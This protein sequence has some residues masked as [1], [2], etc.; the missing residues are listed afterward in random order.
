MQPRIERLPEK[1][2]IGKQTT[3]SLSD[4]KTGDLWRSFMPRR[5]EIMNAI[6]SNLYS[7]QLYDDLY[8]TD[9]NP[10]ATFEKWAAIAVNDFQNIPD[11]MQSFLLE[12]GRYAVFSY[13]GSNTDTRIFEYIFTNWL[14]NSAYDLDNRPHFEILGYNYKNNDPDSEEEIWI[15]IKPKNTTTHH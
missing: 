1:K 13:K 14:P 2:L 3:M 8:F 11:G 12:G 7:L 15:P 4:N 10:N 5:K 9:F 6:S